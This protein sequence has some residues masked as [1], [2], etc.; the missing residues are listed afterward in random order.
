MGTPP[1]VQLRKQCL[2]QGFIPCLCELGSFRLAFGQQ[3][4]GKRRWW[5]RIQVGCQDY[6]FTFILWIFPP[7]LPLWHSSHLH[8]TAWKRNT[9]QSPVP[10]GSPARVYYLPPLLPPAV[11]AQAGLG[12]WATWENSVLSHMGWGQKHVN[13]LSRGSTWKHPS[14]CTPP[15]WEV[16][17]CEQRAR[18][19]KTTTKHYRTF[20]PTVFFIKE[21]MC[22]MT[23]SCSFLFELHT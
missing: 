10:D 1:C 8:C 13:L 23:L 20:L 12:C 19:H 17:P 9:A 18:R 5:W 15:A 4:E 3:R 6:L 14:Q 7:P 21:C 22:L 16:V 11:C 2:K